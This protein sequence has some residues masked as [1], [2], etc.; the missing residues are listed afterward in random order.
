MENIESS[1]E[2]EKESYNLSDT[3]NLTHS[4][5]LNSEKFYKYEFY[6][7]VYFSDKWDSEQLYDH[8]YVYDELGENVTNKALSCSITENVKIIKKFKL[9]PQQKGNYIIFVDGRAFTRKAEKDVDSYYSGHI[10]YLN[11]Q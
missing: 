5:T 11:I 10:H 9:I 4:F 6:I 3:I 2:P 7:T 1:I 8:I